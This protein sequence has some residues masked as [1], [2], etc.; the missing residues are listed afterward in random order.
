[1]IKSI[2]EIKTVEEFRQLL[3]G[4]KQVAVLC[5]QAMPMAAPV[6]NMFANM[7]EQLKDVAF[8]Q[9]NIN[10]H[11]ELMRESQCVE[12][13]QPNCVLAY[14]NGK[15]RGNSGNLNDPAAPGRLISFLHQTFSE[16]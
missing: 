16:E 5:Y 10:E 12:M 3:K 7:S 11:P 8:A 1:M 2:K 9:I 14:E 13:M 6:S 4:N 15:L